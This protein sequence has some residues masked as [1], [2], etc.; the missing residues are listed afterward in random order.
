MKFLQEFTKQVK[1]EYESK[2][3]FFNLRIEFEQDF[4]DMGDHVLYVNTMPTV[5]PKL[6]RKRLVKKME[7]NLKA[8]LTEN[9]CKVDSVKFV[10][11]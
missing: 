5:L 6:L 4:F 10:G 2:L 3:R 7:E 8:F 1:E 11:D 9:G